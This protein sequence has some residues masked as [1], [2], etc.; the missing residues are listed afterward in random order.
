MRLVLVMRLVIVRILIGVRMGVAWR[1]AWLFHSLVVAIPGLVALR[2]G[3]IAYHMSG[4][5]TFVAKLQLSGCR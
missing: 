4:H 5:P 3:L 1:H 2:I